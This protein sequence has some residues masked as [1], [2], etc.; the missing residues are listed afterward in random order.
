MFGNCS[1]N[2]DQIERTWVDFFLEVITVPPAPYRPAERLRGAVPVP[3]VIDGRQQLIV[4]VVEGLTDVVDPGHVADPR[5]TPQVGGRRIYVL[6]RREVRSCLSLPFDLVE[7]AGQG[8]QVT[9]R[10]AGL[11]VAHAQIIA[12]GVGRS[13]VGNHGEYER[14]DVPGRYLASALEPQRQVVAESLHG[15][16]DGLVVDLSQLLGDAE[17]HRACSAGH[18]LMEKSFNPQI[19]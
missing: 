18:A 9:H 1:P 12:E 3:V 2:K 10:L 4:D 8:E 13:R 17:D 11:N 6:P 5:P 14:G 19:L 15:R 7:G 16:R